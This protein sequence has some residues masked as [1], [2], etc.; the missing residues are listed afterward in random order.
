[1]KK[2]M[3]CIII[4]LIVVGTTIAQQS[5]I[6]WLDECLFLVPRGEVVGRTILCGI[7]IVP[8]DR[9]EPDGLWIEIAFAVLKSTNPNPA[10]DPIVYLEGGPGGSALSSIDYWSTFY[11]RQDRDIII[12]DQRGA[13]YSYPRLVCDN[14]DV[15]ASSQDTQAYLRDLADCRAQFEADGVD[16]GDYNTINNAH[17]TYDLLVAL[18]YPQW[19]LFGV[20]YGTRLALNIMRDFPQGIRSVIIDGVYPPVVNAYE[21]LPI[22]GYRAFRQLFDDCLA[23]TACNSA[24]PNLQ[25]RLYALIDRLNA[26]PITLADDSEL[27]G[28]G[29]AD[30]LFNFF[31]DTTV[32]PY[33]PLMIDEL[34]KGGQTI[35]NALND[36]ILPLSDKDA[37]EDPVV[38]FADM[39]VTL[40]DMLDEEAFYDIYDEMDQWDLSRDELS[41]ILYAYFDEADADFLIDL[42][43]EIAD[44]DLYR[45]YVML[46]AQDVSDSTGMFDAVECFDEIP[47]NS[48][49]KEAF[50]SADLPP[51]LASF[52]AMQSQVDTCLVWQFAKPPQSETEPVYS[53]IPTLVL[54][55]SYDPITPPAWGI[56]AAQTLSNSTVIEFPAIGHGAVDSADCPS[57]IARAFINDPT[58]P[59]DISC[60]ATMRM[61]FITEMPD[62][63]EYEE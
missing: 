41:D 39:F 14:V 51:Q 5:E 26:N 19:N 49:E 17:D 43:A 7:L 44:D 42:L 18:G 46:I 54:S 29:L 16:I 35:I 27:T 4:G 15:E 1:M 57:A 28:D 53:D 9:D 45:L 37:P 10:P 36:G 20:S 63:S 47:F 56:I 33:L 23:D 21:E 22:N 59:V 32:I 30:A 8:Q 6:E 25:T 34:D 3:W 61:Q 50:R 48:V 31:Y 24:F 62:L 55:G 52:I 13:G 12:F 60:V 58:A 2:M 11:M 40:A 38:N